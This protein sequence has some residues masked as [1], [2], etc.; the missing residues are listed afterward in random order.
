[1]SFQ[2]NAFQ[3]N[4]FQVGISGGAAEPDVPRAP[5]LFD[6]KGR[7]QLGSVFQPV[8]LLLTTLA[9]AAAPFI[10]EDF[11][12]VQVKK[13][14]RSFDLPRNAVLLETAPPPVKQ[15][16]EPGVYRKNVS[17]PFFPARGLDPGAP[18]AAPFEPYSFDSVTARKL[19]SPSATLSQ[20]LPLFAPIAPPFVG[21]SLELVPVKKSVWSYNQGTNTLLLPSVPTTPLI[22]QSEEYVPARKRFPGHSS[23]LVALTPV[24]RLL[25]LSRSR[26]TSSKPFCVSEKSIPSRQ[27]I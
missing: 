3:Q 22:Q 7:K 4:A 9:V 21:E 23:P 20:A 27:R 18:Q 19:Y 13:S 5:L 15:S 26:L 14:L 6:S 24:R 16:L 8:N 25:R 1:M 12:S 11:S 17:G 10:P 2:Q